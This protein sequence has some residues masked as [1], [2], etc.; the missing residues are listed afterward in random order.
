M[1]GGYTGR[2]LDV[3]LTWGEAYVV[4]VPADVAAPLLGGKGTA[5]LLL[6]ELLPRGTD[7]L[8]PD[9][10]VVINTGPLTGTG[11]PGCSRFNLSTRSPLTGRIASSNSGGPFG[12]FLKRAGYDGLILRGRAPRP[13]WL[14]IDE[15]GVVL[16]DATG[17]WGKGAIEVQGERS[18]REGKIAIGPA[19]ENLVKFAA[20][21]SGD[22][23]LARCGVG[24]VLGSKNLKG[25]T[26]RGGGRVAVDRPDGLKDVIGEW[27][28]A[29]KA[30]TVTGEM[31]SKY[32]T[33]VLVNRCNASS[34]LPTRNFKHG[35]FDR[36]EDISGEA[37]EEVL[38]GRSGCHACPVR[39]GRVVAHPRS[40]QKIRGPEY[41]TLALM[42]SNLEIGSL[43]HVLEW[44]RMCDDLG[45]DTISAG[46]TIGTAM[47]LGERGLFH[48]G[49]RFGEVEGIAPLLQDI[50]ARRG[51]GDLLAEGS[52]RLAG[53]FGAA[54]LAH[55]SKGL[56]LP[57]YHPRF[58]WGHALGYATA[59][60]GGCHLDGGYLAFMEGAGLSL[61]RPATV[62]GKH[63][64][65]IFMQDLIQA[66]SAAGCCAFTGFLMIPDPLLQWVDS[67]SVHPLMSR[68]TGAALRLVGLRS[69]VPDKALCFKL[70]TRYCP[71]PPALEAVTGAH[72]TFG[73]FLAAGSAIY[74]LE[75]EMN[76]AEASSWDGD[77]V[78]GTY[79]VAEGLRMEDAVAAYFRM[80]GW[81]ADGRPLS[82]SPAPVTIRRTRLPGTGVE[83][84]RE[85]AEKPVVYAR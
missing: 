11:T 47:E 21:M 7:P 4:P 12:M 68:A 31:L 35:T 83:A 71:I 53:R 78:C 15:T 56:E 28:G 41:E 16:R 32:G 51:A 46:A 2:Y 10:V 19:G 60:R 20:V 22:R 77:A 37:L 34:L 3:D 29:L 63:A 73:R 49:V 80:R 69:Y 84:A 42:G 81:T 64:L 18:A 62:A 58:A 76:L 61:L 75:R 85:R 54:D 25:A 82:A 79:A 40:G 6:R 39:C 48:A 72:Q 30:H 43:P 57:G 45:M 36:A 38:E 23:V 14:E 52:L 65:V 67:H 55:H 9:N 33:S 50:A 13:V 59:N 27:S 74:A 17:L 70:P 1:P 44:N 8:S 5:A 66:I 26:A 24:A